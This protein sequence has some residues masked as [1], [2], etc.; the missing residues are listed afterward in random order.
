[1]QEIFDRVTIVGTESAL[2]ALVNADH[3]TDAVQE[4]VAELSDDNGDEAA[5]L[6]R[7]RCVLLGI[8]ALA[9]VLVVAGV[10]FALSSSPTYHP[11]GGTKSGSTNSRDQGATTKTGRPHS[12]GSTSTNSSA[13]GQTSRPS[14]GSAAHGSSGS[15]QSVPAGPSGTGTD[16]GSGA[17]GTGPSGPGSGTG[18]TGNSGTSGT[19]PSGTGSGSKDSGTT[20]TLPGGGAVTLPTATIPGGTQLTTPPVTVPIQPVQLPGGTTV[21]TPKVTIPSL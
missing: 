9:L 12:I 18:N 17:V 13:K 4:P 14:S 20:I 6:N 15:S 10:A 11:T 5:R 3:T 21:T 2:A 8:L 19:D 1:L 16:T 7:R